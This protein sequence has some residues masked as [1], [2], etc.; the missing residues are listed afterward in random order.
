MKI[1]ITQYIPKEGLTEL[2]EN[3]EVLM[4]E[5]GGFT[6]DAQKKLIRDVDIL[7]SLFSSAVPKE[8]LQEAKNLKMISNFGVGYNNIDLTF[9]KKRKIIVTNTPDPVT[10]P[11]A[12]HTLGL[13]LS[14]LRRI[15]EMD[16]KL[17]QQKVADWKVMSNLGHT[18]NGKT[19]G[20]IGMGKIG[21]ATTK[22]AQAFGMHV[23]YYSR[24]QKSED[25]EQQLNTLW[26]PF[27]DL[28]KSA[29]IISLHV[30]LTSQTRHLIGAKELQLMKN[31]AYLI[32]TARGPIIDE[33]ALVNAL[34]ANKI[35][36][37]GLDVF[38]EE[39]KIHPELLNFEN[40]VLT[41]HIGTGTIETRIETAQCAADNIM[42]FINGEEIPNRVF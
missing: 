35:A 3:H 31:T 29:D 4:P 9:A 36:G 39:P 24:T 10:L 21:Q 27:N 33:K 12:E 15:A 28:L 23:L 42:A 8:L 18:L 20:I 26:I 30:P 19:L 13:M 34:K 2:F 1:L 40:V 6:F 7:L 37:A 11:T 5:S 25:L 32:N 14:L 16:Q 17:K 22:I 41:P 38:E